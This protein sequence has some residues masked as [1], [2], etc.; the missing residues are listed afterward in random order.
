[1][2][3]LT[4]VACDLQ[5]CKQAICGPEAL[6]SGLRV[7]RKRFAGLRV[8]LGAEVV[9]VAGKQFAGLGSN[10]WPASSQES[11]RKCCELPES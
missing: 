1:M 8:A 6:G 10:L 7:A 11:T 9:R 3:R 2:P 4:L 5:A